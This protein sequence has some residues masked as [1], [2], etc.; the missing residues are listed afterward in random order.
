MANRPTLLIFVKNPELGKAKTRLAQS[1]GP[2][3]ALKIYRA[4]LGHTRQLAQAVDAQRM[5]FYSAFIDEKDQWPNNDFA[6]YLQVS[7]GLGER[8]TDAFAQ[9][10]AEGGGPVLIIGSDC[11]QLTPA[12]VEQGIKALEIHDFVIGPAEDGGYYLLGMRAFHPEVFHNIAWSTETV[13]TQTLEV[14]SSNDWS[15][16]LLPVLSDIDYEEDWE[17]HGWKI[18]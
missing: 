12:I 11:A 3:Q 9:A 7:G 2:E 13:L 6:K 8:M 16:S 4:L 18:D 15:H 1:V 14:V 10:F 17:K 5:L